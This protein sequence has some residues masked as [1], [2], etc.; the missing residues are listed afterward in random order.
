[1]GT[2]QPSSPAHDRYTMI[3]FCAL[4]VFPLALVLK[5]WI[6]E[7]SMVIIGLTFLYQ[8]YRTRDWAWVKTPP[9][10]IAFG[11]WLYLYFVVTPLA[12]NPMDSLQRSI[13]W[14]RFPLFFAAVVFWM[15]NYTREMKRIT[16]WMLLIICVVTVDA[17]VQYYTGVSPLSGREKPEHRLTGPLTKVVVGMYLAK[18]SFPISGFASL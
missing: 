14:W 12:I 4:G 10:L 8:S 15:S 6:G 7:L 16:Y 13:V 2:M 17:F 11:L 18:L 9:M 3:A 1:M 5:R